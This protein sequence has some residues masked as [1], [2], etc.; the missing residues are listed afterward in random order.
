MAAPENRR[1]LPVKLPPALRFIVIGCAAAAV[2]LAV[3]RLL[4][5]AQLLAP[6]TANVVGWLVAFG[7]SFVGHLRWT[8]AQQ[9]AP[10][11]HALPRFFALS[12]LGFAV[13]ELAYVVALRFIPWR[14]DVLLAGVLAG[15]AV[16]TFVLSKLWAFRSRKP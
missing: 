11:R 1:P 2:H 13:N 8:F 14:Y 9:R 3:V 12:A 6:L 10:L 15:V 7:V 5:G 16:G 4:V